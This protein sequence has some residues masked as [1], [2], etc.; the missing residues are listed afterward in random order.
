MFKNVVQKLH[1][2]QEV[3]IENDVATSSSN[4]SYTQYNYNY[5]R[6][7]SYQG[8]NYR[9]NKF[10][11]HSRNNNEQAFNRGTWRNNDRSNNSQNFRRGY[12]TN[13]QGRNAALQREDQ[14]LS[15]QR[16]QRTYVP[17]TDID[18]YEATNTDVVNNE[19]RITTDQNRHM[20]VLQYYSCGFTCVST[21]TWNPMIEE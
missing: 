6:D 2:S 7:N 18:S 12:S 17:T 3:F 21:D 15:G 16:Q 19:F 10:P 20:T 9:N 14:N 1:R 4:I 5:S 13:R 11:S 8:N